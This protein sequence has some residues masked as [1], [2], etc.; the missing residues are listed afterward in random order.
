MKRRGAAMAGHLALL[1][2]AAAAAAAPAAGP[3]PTPQANPSASPKSPPDAPVS[4][5]ERSPPYQPQLLRLAEMIGALAY[6]RDLCGAGDG[7]K[8]RDRMAALLDAEG[9]T[10]TRRSLL[11]GAYNQGF[12]D[13]QT[14]YRTCTPAADAIVSRY[15]SETARIASEIAARYG[16]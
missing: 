1:V 7:E 16:G 5:A 14:N 4:P 8:F 3:K 10:E 6:L 15:L 12:R 11:A 2:L 9:T 13:Y